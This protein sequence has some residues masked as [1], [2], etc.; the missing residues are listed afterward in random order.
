MKSRLPKALHPLAGRPMIDHVLANVAALSPVRTILVTGPEFEAALEG[1]GGA[2]S[3]VERVL[4]EP[5]DGTAHA[6]AACRRLL[7]GFEGDVLVVYV[8]TPLLQGETLVRLVRARQE[9]AGAPAAVLAF[10]PPDPAGYGRLV[11]DSEGRLLRIVEAGER[12]DAGGADGL[13]NAGPMVVEGPR[14]FDLLDRIGN[15][16]AR[17]EYYL[18]DLPAVI[19]S[20]GG[21]C[22]V[23]EAPAEE[24]L[25]VNDRAQLAVAEGVVQQRLRA[26]AMAG[27]ATLADPAT[28]WLSF[29]TRI[30]ADVAVGPC[31]ALGPGVVIEDDV[32]IRAFSH[33]EGVRVRRGAVVGPFA[34]L[35]PAS[36]VGEGARVGNFVELKNAAV[37]PGAKISHLSYVGDATVGE[38]ANIGAGVI[39]CNYDGY[40]KSRTEIGA[41]AFIGSNASLVAPVA[42]GAGALVGA[43]S[44]ITE[45]VEADAVAVARG[46]QAQRKGAAKRRRARRSAG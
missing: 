27:G 13:C 15:D 17:G 20:Q 46:D 8:D 1:T 21:V 9:T 33:L 18:S 45:D 30:G 36:D 44:T 10:R 31:V 11:L 2:A 35:R 38:G 29:D 39:T 24:C 7:E 40:A 25:G 19:A 37:E 42:I 14:L 34:R 41:G 22:A 4:Q 26:H 28:V 23:V 5:R 12:E 16:N 43:G 32:E 3:T 6:V